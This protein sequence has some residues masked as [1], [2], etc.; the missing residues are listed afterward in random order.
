M[1]PGGFC[2]TNLLFHELCTQADRNLFRKVLS[3]HNHVLHHLLPPV[4][5]ISQTYSLRPRAHNRFLSEHSI[6]ILS[7]IYYMMKSIDSFTAYDLLYFVTV[8][9]ISA[10]FNCVLSTGHDKL[11]TILSTHSFGVNP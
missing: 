4:L 11:I 10:L 3:Y 7:F 5:S 6:V 1:H 8:L 9:N 2:S